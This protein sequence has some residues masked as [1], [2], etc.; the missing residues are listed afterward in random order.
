MS[1]AEPCRIVVC[2]ETATQT[3]WFIVRNT[4]ARAYCSK[5]AFEMM[6]RLDGGD[7]PPPHPLEDPS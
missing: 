1:R 5:H 2:S 7:T 6:K 4:E 3:I